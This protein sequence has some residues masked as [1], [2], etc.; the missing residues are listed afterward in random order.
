MFKTED[1]YTVDHMPQWSDISLQL[2]KEF[3]SIKV[4]KL[5]IIDAGIVIER[6]EYEKF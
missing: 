1:L 4:L 5:E 6:I 3:E 2:Y